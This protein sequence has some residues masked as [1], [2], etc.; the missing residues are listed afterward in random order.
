M[1]LQSA[2][3]IKAVEV[4]LETEVTNIGAIGLY[5]KMGFANQQSPDFTALPAAPTEFE[6]AKTNLQGQ[7]YRPS[8][9]Q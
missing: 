7:S 2:K 6:L 1:F 4:N 9:Y 3:E 8:H 5:E